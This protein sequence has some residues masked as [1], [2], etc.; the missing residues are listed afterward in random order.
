LANKLGMK[1]IAPNFMQYY[2]G[3]KTVINKSTVFYCQGI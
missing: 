2:Y 1:A 3:D